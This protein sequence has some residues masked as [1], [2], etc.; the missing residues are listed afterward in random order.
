M[1]EICW[2]CGGPVCPFANAIHL[3]LRHRFAQQC[4]ARLNGRMG[5]SVNE[6]AGESAKL[7]GQ[8]RNM[9]VAIV[10][11]CN[12]LMTS[13]DLQQL[14]CYSNC[15]SKGNGQQMSF[16]CISQAQAHTRAHTHT[17]FLSSAFRSHKFRLCFDG[18]ARLLLNLADKYIISYWMDSSESVC[19]TLCAQY[20]IQLPFITLDGLQPAHTV[21]CNCIIT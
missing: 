21:Y 16:L 12:G 5:A 15:C 1:T 4:A 7:N 11:V 17:W 19:C 3:N 6:R 2:I 14:S 10:M 18:P 20:A 13:K 9:E 8:Q